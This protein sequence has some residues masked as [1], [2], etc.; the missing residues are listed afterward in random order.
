VSAAAKAGGK[1]FT[2]SEVRQQLRQHSDMSG[3]NNSSDR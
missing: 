1:T 3:A 2:A